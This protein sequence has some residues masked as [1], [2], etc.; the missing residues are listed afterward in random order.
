M[1]PVS[2]SPSRPLIGI[3]ASTRSG[4]RWADHAL[5]HEQDFVWRGYSGGMPVLI[6]CIAG[7]SG[8]PDHGDAALVAA[9]VA[10]L[11]GLLLTGG[12]DIDPEHYSEE[13]HRDLGDVDA[14][15][16][17]LELAAVSAAREL[18][19][20]MLG[21]CRG[22]QLLAVAFGGA[23]YQDLESQLNGVI[24]HRQSK[25]PRHASHAVHVEPGSRLAGVVG[26]GGALRVNS[27]HHQAVKR[28]PEGFR[29]SAHAADG[30]IEAMEATDPRHGFVL[31]VQWHPETLWRRDEPSRRLFRALVEAAAAAPGLAAG[32]P[33]ATRR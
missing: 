7:A 18:R 3:T 26:Q 16:D 15:K 25:D 2:A 13:P 10:R 20:P 8:E 30:V 1:S 33:A 28:L 31:G 17:A 14:A 22:V 24:L 19:L 27:Y 23:L 9:T 12:L 29:A 5:S 21:I 11:D 6:P 32:Y 4:G